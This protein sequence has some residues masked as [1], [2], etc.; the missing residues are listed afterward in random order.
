MTSIPEDET[1]EEE[2]KVV[3]PLNEVKNDQINYH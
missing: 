1:L 3:R 2:L